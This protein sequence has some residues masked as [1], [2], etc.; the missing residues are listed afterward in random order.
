MKQL[1]QPQSPIYIVTTGTGRA[2]KAHL[3]D[4]KGEAICGK[5]GRNQKTVDSE[6]VENYYQKCERC[7]KLYRER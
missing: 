5:A 3:P 7:L 4:K 1:S 2:G 6:T